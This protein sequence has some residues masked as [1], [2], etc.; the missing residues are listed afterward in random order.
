M[1]APVS[2]ASK[3]DPT[4]SSGTRRPSPSRHSTPDAQIAPDPHPPTAMALFE[5]WHLFLCLVFR[6]PE[7]T[8][9]KL[10]PCRSNRKETFAAPGVN[11]FPSRSAQN[12]AKS[13]D[14]YHILRVLRSRDRNLQ[15][16]FRIPTKKIPPLLSAQN[17]RTSPRQIVKKIA[18][19]LR[20]LSP[21][22]PSY[23]NVG[24]TSS[25][26]A[27]RQFISSEKYI[28][29]FPAHFPNIIVSNSRECPLRNRDGIS[30]QPMTRLVRLK[31]QNIN[32][33]L[34]L[35]ELVLFPMGS[36]PFFFSHVG[37]A[38]DDAAGRRVF[39]GISSFLRPC[40]PALLHLQLASLTS[41]LNTPMSRKASIYP[42]STVICELIRMSLYIQYWPPERAHPS[43][44][45]RPRPYPPPPPTPQSFN[46]TVPTPTRRVQGV[47]SF[48]RRL[49]KTPRRCRAAL[50]AA[51]PFASVQTTG[52]HS[53][54]RQSS[55]RVV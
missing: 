1:V 30:I 53:S 6:P 17:D 48:R 15:H 28:Y 46:T 22:S 44:N 16:P 27:G 35:R 3:F 32:C 55:V 39:S 12:E 4:V 14:D 7:T 37:M 36:L 10:F 51:N 19:N 43:A 34:A 25:T 33:T 38:P 54:A 8:P 11:N 31:R 50:D 47:C 40:I 49:D 13:N 26:L 21:I 2:S 41:A 5:S 23:L 29:H 18:I 42:H 52:L 9:G 45:M 20:L 24:A